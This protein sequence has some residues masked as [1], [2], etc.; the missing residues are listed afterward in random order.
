MFIPFNVMETNQN[1]W[2]KIGEK[3]I[4]DNPWISLTEFDVITATNVFA[5]VDNLEDFVSGIPKVLS[6]DGI[7]II[8]VPYLL[9]LIMQ[10]QFDT[11]MGR[12]GYGQYGGYGSMNSLYDLVDL[13]ISNIQFEELGKVFDEGF[14]QIELSVGK[15]DAAAA[16]EIKSIFNK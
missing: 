2:K 1:P 10:N 11:I 6:N 14:R 5:H 3:L 8:E 16:S 7:L 12:L 4:Y 15:I 13:G 9:N